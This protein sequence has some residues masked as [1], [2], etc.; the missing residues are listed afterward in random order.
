VDFMHNHDSS[1]VQLLKQQI[2][3]VDQRRNEN[4]AEIFPELAKALHNE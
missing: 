1:D 4:F 2:D 3:L